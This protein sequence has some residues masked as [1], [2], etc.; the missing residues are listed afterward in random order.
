MFSKETFSIAAAFNICKK[1]FNS[2]HKRDSQMF[3]NKVNRVSLKTEATR[4]QSL[5]NVCF[6]CEIWHALFSFY[7]RFNILPFA[8][9]RMKYP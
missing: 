6:F 2:I 7:L 1:E 9:L 3:G 8:L 5:L 4:K